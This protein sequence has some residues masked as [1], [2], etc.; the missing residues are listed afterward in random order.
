MCD[1]LVELMEDYVEERL[2]SEYDKGMKNGRDKERE[3]GIKSLIHTC[4][5]LGIPRQT[6][7]LQ[8]SEQ[9]RLTDESAEEYVEK[10]WKE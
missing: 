8:L 7:T 10:F 9:Y 3:A 4:R 1:A 5:N 2:K 6:A